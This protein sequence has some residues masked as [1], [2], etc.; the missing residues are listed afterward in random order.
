[1]KTYKIL[2]EACDGFFDLPDEIGS[3]AIEVLKKYQS[4]RG[5]ISPWFDH[6]CADKGHKL[7]L[8][9]EETFH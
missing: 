4:E 7:T 1:M 9:T 6:P 2:C 3:E 8:C 5:E